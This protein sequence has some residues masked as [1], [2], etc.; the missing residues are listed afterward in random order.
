MVEVTLV[1]IIEDVPFYKEYMKY[2]SIDR[3]LKIIKYKNEIDKKRSLL[4]ELLIKKATNQALNIP[5][6]EIKISYNP[7]GKPYIDNVRNFKFNV[8]HSGSY[9]VIA[10]SKGKVG[11]DIEQINNVDSGISDRFYTEKENE[12]ISFFE[13]EE[14]KEEAFYAIWTLKESYVKAL[15]KGLRIPLN[16]FEF[17][18]DKNMNVKVLDYSRK[19]MFSFYT[20]KIEDHSLSIC[21]QGQK[22]N[23][24]FRFMPEKDLYNFYEGAAS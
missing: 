7:Y 18:I 12:Y 23:K 9:V 13:S 22:L 19:E 24:E 14:K 11:I 10:T 16:S 17:E 6:N 21:F 3:K 1:K 5:I 4:T 8:S 20:T 2:V 15:G